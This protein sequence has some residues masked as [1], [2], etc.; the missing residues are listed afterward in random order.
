[1]WTFVYMKK[2]KNPISPFPY[3]LASSTVIMPYCLC[4][5]LLPFIHLLSQSPEFFCSA[6]NN[7]GILGEGDLI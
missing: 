6:D 4:G 2:E 1:M 3:L 5:A 7:P